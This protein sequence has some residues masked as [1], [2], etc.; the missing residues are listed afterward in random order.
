[1]KNYIPQ[2]I[3]ITTF[4][5]LATISGVLVFTN[6]DRSNESTE[7]SDDEFI[8]VTFEDSNEVFI[9]EVAQSIEKQRQGLM[10][11]EE[12]PINEGM[13]FVYENEQNLTFWMKNTLISL[14]IIFLD[15]SYKIL[16]I[17]QNTKTN[18]T[19]ERYSSSGKAKYVIEL[20]AGLTN[21]LNLQTNDSVLIKRST[22]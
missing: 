4:L 22:Q 11:V 14:D 7:Y 10:F 13:I 6:I 12:M 8:E 5:F 19:T 18:Q 9:L 15:E 20:N 16:N 1:M 21:D 3:S 17:H 2:I